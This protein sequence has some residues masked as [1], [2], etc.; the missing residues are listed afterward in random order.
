MKSIEKIQAFLPIGYLYLVILGII[1][2]SVCYYQLGINIL[3]YSSIMDIL[4]SPI[5]VIT[6]HPIITAI[7]I[8]LLYYPFF[9]QKMFIKY[10][11]KK[12]SKYVFGVKKENFNIEDAES[13]EFLFN[14][15]IT[16]I[17]WIY[18]SLFIGFGFARGR[19][20]YQKIIN[21]KLEFQDK[22]NFNTGDS[23]NIYLIDSNSS[24]YFYIPEGSNHIEIAPLGSI[25]SIEIIK[26]KRLNPKKD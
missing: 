5:S 25:K 6:A 3:K 21:H 14:K 23:K 16:T 10:H 11:H 8:S 24:Y 18:L 22:L 19:S 12:W 7:F 9:Q 15:L 4:I 17:M 13:K 26:N 1:K 20:I 2:E